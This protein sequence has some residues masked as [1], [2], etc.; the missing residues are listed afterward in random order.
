MPKQPPPPSL[1]RGP[2][3]PPPCEPGSSLH[4]QL[5]GWVT[6]RGLTDARI[7]WPWTHDTLDGGTG[8]KRSLVLAGDLLSAVR[9]ESVAA[10][11]YHWGVDRK[12][13]SRWRHALE[14]GRMTPGTAAIWAA[15]AS[16]L[17]RKRTRR[18]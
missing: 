10:I 17:H 15:A 13:V 8:S 1:I 3:A 18:A 2:Y 5:R 4:C 6:V 7:P 16:K 9:V 12:I 14:V 11:A